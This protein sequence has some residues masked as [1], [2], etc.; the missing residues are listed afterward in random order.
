MASSPFLVKRLTHK[1]GFMM[2]LESN[3]SYT[4]SFDQVTRPTNISFAG[5]FFGLKPNDYLILKYY[6][7][8]KPDQVRFDSKNDLTE[9]FT[10][11]TGLNKHADWYWDNSSFSLSFIV[12]NDQNKLPFIDYSVNFN[13]IKCRYVGCIPPVSPAL[14]PPVTSRPK[15]VIF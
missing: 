7:S 10:P 12:K 11:L 13:A 5:T 8:Q 9:S 2:A 6:L 15:D 3:Q 1:N 4:L 14:K